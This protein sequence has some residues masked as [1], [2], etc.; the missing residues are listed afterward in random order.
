[1]LWS[2]AGTL[3]WPARWPRW[4]CCCAT[5][6]RPVA[7]WMDPVA[8]VVLGLALVTYVWRVVRFKPTR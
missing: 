2:A 1:M 3:Q 7:H 4:G 8:K 5:T 6:T